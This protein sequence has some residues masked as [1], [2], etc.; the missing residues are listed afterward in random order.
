MTA[1][2]LLMPGVTEIDTVVIRPS[3]AMPKDVFIRLHRLSVAMESMKRIGPSR[4]VWDE[5]VMVEWDESLAEME[6]EGLHRD[7]FSASMELPR[8]L[9]EKEARHG[10]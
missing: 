1:Q 9:F 3:K 8:W 6:Y 7:W 10:G 5:S 4:V 2:P